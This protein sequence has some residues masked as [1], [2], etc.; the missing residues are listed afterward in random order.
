MSISETQK[1]L[2]RRG[3]TLSSQNK[4][5]L[6]RKKEKSL[7]RKKGNFEILAMACAPKRIF[8]CWLMLENSTGTGINHE[9]AAV[10][11]K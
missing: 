1:R 6:E 8:F 3:G 9:T 11:F 4:Y 2:L 7:G 5:A 10:F